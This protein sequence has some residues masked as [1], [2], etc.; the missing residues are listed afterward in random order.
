MDEKLT[1][2]MDSDVIELGKRYARENGKSLSSI[3]EDYLRILLEQGQHRES[4]GISADLASFVGIADI[5]TDEDAKA[6][7]VAHLE[8]K[9]A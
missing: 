8:A 9:G 5:G 1:L 4:R 3:V 6:E 2:K 7:H